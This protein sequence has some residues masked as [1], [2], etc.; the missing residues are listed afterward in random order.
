MIE[1]VRER[2]AGNR[3]PQ[4]IHPGEVRLALLPGTVHLCEVHL[5]VRAVQRPPVPKSALQ[6]AQLTGLVLSR[7][8]ALQLL[9]HGLRLKPVVLLEQRLR[10][11]ELLSRVVFARLNQAAIWSSSITS[12]PSLNLIPVTTFAR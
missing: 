8:A 4:R 1:Q 2:V 10:L 7:V 9:E 5:L 3:H 11:R 12:I 6:G